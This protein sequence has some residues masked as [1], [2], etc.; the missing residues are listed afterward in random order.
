MVA[1]VAPL[2]L[3]FHLK[4]LPLI[5]LWTAL[6]LNAARPVGHL[7][8][9]KDPTRVFLTRPMLVLPSQPS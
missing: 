3:P 7:A 4:P 5:G 9:E 2:V 6:P 8:P 1:L